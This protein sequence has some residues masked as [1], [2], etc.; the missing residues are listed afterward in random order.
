MAATH[1]LGVIK[2]ITARWDRKE[3]FVF[4]DTLVVVSSGEMFGRVLATQFGLI[5]MLIYGLGRKR[6]EAA[7]EQRRQQSAEQLLALDPKNIQIVVRNIV[8]ARLSSG[9]L[10]GKLTLSL[11]DG[12]H[13]QFSWAKSDNQYEQVLGLLRGA[14]GTKLVDEKKAA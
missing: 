7:A 6:R 2:G 8:D 4:A 10:T 1:A 14:L 5:G 13:P 12:T 3:M 11:V 9:L